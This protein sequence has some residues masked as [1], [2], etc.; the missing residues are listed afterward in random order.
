MGL[1]PGK[2]YTAKMGDP[3]VKEE[4]GWYDEDG[5][6]GAGAA[7][8]MAERTCEVI[9][10]EMGHVIRELREK[11]VQ[12]DIVRGA[13]KQHISNLENEIIRLKRKLGVSVNGTY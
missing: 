3:V 6:Y 13:H 11:L 1:E 7:Q 10:D 9:M 5:N 8:E 2:T 12:E 4:G